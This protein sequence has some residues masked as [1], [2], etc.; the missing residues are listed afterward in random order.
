MKYSWTMARVTTNRNPRLIQVR[1]RGTAGAGS[2]PSTESATR[3]GEE[4]I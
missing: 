4:T 1:V 2:S 3:K